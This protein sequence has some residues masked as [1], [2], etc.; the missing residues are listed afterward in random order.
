MENRAE[1]AWL[2]C[3]LFF[4]VL[5]GF[6]I[7]SQKPCV[8]WG[9]TFDVSLESKNVHRLCISNEKPI[10]C[11]AIANDT[12][13]ES[14]TRGVGLSFVP[15]TFL[16]PK[17]ARNKD[18]KVSCVINKKYVSS[19][20]ELRDLEMAKAIDN[21]FKLDELDNRL[22]ALL[23]YVT[24]TETITNSTRWLERVRLHM[25]SEKAPK[26]SLDDSEFLSR[27]VYSRDC[28]G[29]VDEWT[30]WIEPISITAR[31]P[32]GFS[33]CKNTG[34]YFTKDKPRVG[35]SDV[36]YVLL[37][38]GHSLYNQTHTASGRRIGSTMGGKS[39]RKN[40]RSAKHYLLDAGTSTFDSS[41]FWFTCGYSQVC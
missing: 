12:S 9:N 24:S 2:K 17:Y 34:K 41:L 27:F 19:P 10:C 20:L 7:T 15:S 29:E 13:P 14:E 35:R 37:Q 40:G 8:K 18:P 25:M 6:V 5:C 31:H 36:D 1:Q 33:K 21:N 11:A 28:G 4:S 3:L 23:S 16:S 26:F 32:F 30:E 39:S 22:T 38:S